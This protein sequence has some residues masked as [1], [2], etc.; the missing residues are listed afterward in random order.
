MKQVIIGFL[1]TIVDGGYN[2]KRWQRWRPT[3]CTCLQEDLPVHRFELLVTSGAEEKLVDRVSMD[4]REVSPETEV[5]VHWLEIDD[6]WDL[7][8]VFGT[9]YDFAHGYPFDEDHESYLYHITT[10][11]HVSQICAFLLTETRHVPARLLQTAPGPDGRKD[12]KGTY[13]IIDLDLSRYDQLAARFELE[14]EGDIAF[15]KQGI[16]TR[17]HAFNA[18]MDRIERVALR[19]TEPVLLTGPTGAGKSA[20]ARRI[21]ELKAKRSQLKG[22]FVEVNCA[23]LRGDTAMSTLFGH[24]K[25]AFTGAVNDRPGLLLAAHRGMLFLDEVGELGADEQ[26]ML[27]RAIEEKRFLPMGADAEASS[28][29]QL[30]CGTNRDL[31]D[32]VRSGR[33]RGD[34]L[35]RLNLWSFALP[36]LAERREDIEPNL[37]YE[38]ELFMRKAGRRVSFNQ[39]ARRSFLRFASDPAS[40]WAGNFRDLNAAITRLATLAPGGRITPEEVKLEV[41]RLQADWRLHDSDPAQTADLDLL[42]ALLGEETVR[43]L[44]RFDRVQLADVIRV[45][46]QSRALSEAGRTLFAASRQRRKST[47]DADRLRKYLARFD[48]SWETLQA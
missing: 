17:N 36:G 43:E 3:V 27:L 47:N 2:E 4:I 31:R 39:E 8:E 48:L 45:C 16:P 44:D 29:F 13:Q 24:R 9:L 30:I 12:P 10:G 1:G 14:R 7:Q 28:D 32:E 26:A 15:L 22:E 6:P 34:L 41:E 40:I 11:S 33:F 38:L 25:G 46:R 23:T 37:E 42:E 5:R 18:L 21:Y 35:A 19:S 20:L